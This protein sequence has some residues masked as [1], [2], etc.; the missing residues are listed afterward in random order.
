[1]SRPFEDGPIQNHYRLGLET[2]IICINVKGIPLLLT[3]Y[4]AWSESNGL[5]NFLNIS[6]LSAC[7]IRHSSIDCI[8]LTLKRNQIIFFSLPSVS[9]FGRLV[10]VLIEIGI[11]HVCS[12]QCPQRVCDIYI[13][14]NPSVSYGI[15]KSFLFW[16]PGKSFWLA[17]RAVIGFW[18]FII[19]WSSM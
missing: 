5:W 6:T 15:F 9:Q 17:K 18:C 7:R 13:I 8:I 10:Q 4:L 1:M 12:I 3:E 19:V 16:L 11:F 14:S 2:R